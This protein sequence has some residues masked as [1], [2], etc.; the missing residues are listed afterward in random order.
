MSISKTIVVSAT[1]SANII[2]WHEVF[3][4]KFLV[5]VA[6]GI[7]GLISISQTK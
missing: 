2:I 1:V 4:V 6:I 3:G 5:I 7:I